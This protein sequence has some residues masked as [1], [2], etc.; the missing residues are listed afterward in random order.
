VTRA[1]ASARRSGASAGAKLKGREH[2]RRSPLRPPRPPR[3]R[4]PRPRPLPR[5]RRPQARAGRAHSGGS[6]T[7]AGTISH[8]GQPRPGCARPRARVSRRR[9]QTIQ[10][11]MS[12]GRVGRYRGRRMCGAARRRWGTRAVPSSRRLQTPDRRSIGRARTGR[13][14]STRL[15]TAPSAHTVPRRSPDRRSTGRACRRRG[16]SS[17]RGT[18]VL[19]SSRAR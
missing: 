7:S 15:G 16:R 18:G 2:Q 10:R 17:W 11:G 4:P 6:S 19:V 9:S 3:P 13:G 1:G 12:S 14:R 5:A 8:T